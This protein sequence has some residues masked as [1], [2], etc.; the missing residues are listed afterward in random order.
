MLATSVAAISSENHA[1]TRWSRS[2][3]SSAGAAPDSSL[4]T[5]ERDALFD[6]VGTAT[7]SDSRRSNTVRRRSRLLKPLRRWL[8]ARDLS[9]CQVS[10]KLIHHSEHVL[11]GDTI[12]FHHEPD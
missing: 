3:Q 4:G 6:V 2:G 7:C 9:L 10:A 8:S 12:A 11:L 1:R 5:S